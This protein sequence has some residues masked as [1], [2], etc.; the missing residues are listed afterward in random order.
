MNSFCRALAIL[1]INPDRLHQADTE[2]VRARR[3][4]ETGRALAYL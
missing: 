1:K 3:R 4:A 2:R